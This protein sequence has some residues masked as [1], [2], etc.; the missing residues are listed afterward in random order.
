MVVSVFRVN[1]WKWP[2]LPAHSLSKLPV[3]I[4]TSSALSGIGRCN[5]LSSLETANFLGLDAAYSAT[6]CLLLPPLQSA[7]A[8]ITSKLFRLC[9]HNETL[10]PQI[11]SLEKRARLEKLWP[12]VDF[13]SWKNPVKVSR[14]FRYDYDST[15]VLVSHLLCALA[16]G[17]KMQFLV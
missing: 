16:S 15:V 5:F 2:L 3:V 9:I 6:A 13:G 17:V 7:F 10:F 11:Y 4:N 14:I 12:S 8:H 1:F